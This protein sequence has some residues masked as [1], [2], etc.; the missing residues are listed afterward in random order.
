AT[1]KVRCWGEGAGGFLGY[2][3]DQTIGDDEVPA[4]LAELQIGGSV[5]QLAMGFVHT[6]ALLSNGKVR[7]WGSSYDGALGYGNFDNIGDDEAAGAG[8]DVDLGG[9]VARIAVGW[10]HTCA[11]LTD[12]RLRCW[13]RNSEGQ[14]GYAH[15]ATIGDDETPAS[16]GD[17]PVGSPVRQVALG[18][19]HTCALLTTGKVRCWGTSES[20]QLG[21][22]NTQSVSPASAAADVNVGGSVVQIAAGVAHTCALL[23][24]GAVRC[25]GS[26]NYGELGYPSAG[27]IGDDELPYTALDVA[28]Q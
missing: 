15:S 10:E 13:G 4:G 9:T 17:V 5:V 7:C 21:Y 23:T 20:G 22:G 11:V 1:G 6:C 18:A 16:A 2:G 12:G 3:H 28:V 8:G 14:L 26:N 19:H 25:W 24:T 27:N